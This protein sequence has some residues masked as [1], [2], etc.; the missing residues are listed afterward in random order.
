MCDPNFIDRNSKNSFQNEPSASGLSST[1]L[2]TSNSHSC[3]KHDN[4]VYLQTTYSFINSYNNQ[5]EAIRLVLDGGSQMTFIKE[6]ISRQLNLPI[7]SIVAFG[8][9]YQAHREFVGRCY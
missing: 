5:N 2:F 4:P 8:D 1:N 6:S 9:G 3:E 7:V